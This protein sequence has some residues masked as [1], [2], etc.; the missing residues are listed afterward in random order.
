MI[1]YMKDYVT[2][3]EKELNTDLL[4]K[5]NDKPLL[6]YILESWYSLEVMDG[7]KILDWTYTERESEIDINDYIFKRE[8][9]K[10]RKE[11]YDF[12]FID[13]SRLGL[14]TVRVQ[15]QVE[16]KDPQTNRMVTHKQI[17][18]KSML[19]PLQDE[20]GLYHLNGKDIYMIYQMVEKSTYTASNSVILKSL[21]PFAIRRYITNQRDTKGNEYKLPYYTIELFKK[22]I[23]IMLIYATKGLNYAVQFALDSPYLVMNF[24]EEENEE[25]LENIYFQISNRLFIKVN[26]EL[27]ENFTF[28]KSVV[29]GILQISTN[30][31]VLDKIDDEELWLKKLGGG[32]AQKGENLLG[33]AQRLMDETTRKILRLDMTHKHDVLS[34]TR[35][36]CEEYNDLRM[37][38]N[39]DLSNKRLRSNEI[40]SALMTQEFSTRLNRIMSLGKK[41]TID[42]YRELFSFPGDV[43]IQAINTAGIQRYNDVINDMNFFSKY[44]YTI[45]GPNSLGNKNSN[46]IGIRYRGLHHSFIGHIDMTVCG[47]SDRVGQA[48]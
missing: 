28:V 25:D 14:L 36:M 21:M 32:N 41:A 2:T 24:V 18:K 43:L 29:G 23:E 26:R 35:W 16:V 39:M 40:L 9:G 5:A 31:L 10:K 15:L 22:D 13:D 7:I 33:R 42:N 48:V 20:D 47:N 37:K 46:N 4:T 1:A 8:R 11:K 27:F 19:I 6:D 34:L 12:K 38:D 17:I 45:K 44:K 3:Y 30:R